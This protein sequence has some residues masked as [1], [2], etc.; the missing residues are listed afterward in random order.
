[1]RYI[2]IILIFA[3]ISTGCA[4]KNAF[5]KFN[6]QTEQELSAASLQSSKIKTADKVDGIVSVIYLNKV[7]PD[8]Y[9]KNEYFYVYLYL[10]DEKEMFNPNTLDEIKLTMKLNSKLPVK[11]KKLSHKNKFSHLVSVHSQWMRYFLV[12]F[13]EEEESE[14]SLVLESG[15]S[16]SDALVYQKDEQ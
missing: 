13:E 4:E 12:A 5:S 6:M 14:L 3:L 11:I 9:S 1:M 15:Q 10:K 16:S 7:Y 8:V 2:L